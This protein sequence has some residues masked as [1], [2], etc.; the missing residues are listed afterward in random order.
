MTARCNLP[1][2]EVVRRYVGGES[3]LSLGR[4]Y[5]VCSTTI[6]NHLRRAGIKRR[7]CGA[8]PG[9]LNARKRG[10]PYSSQGQGYLCS[11]DRDSKLTLVHRACWEAYHGAIPKKH[12]VHHIT[13]DQL[14]NRIENLACMTQAVHMRLHAA[15]RRHHDPSRVPRSW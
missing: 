12:I 15:A 13:G 3:T 14:D 7:P 10:G 1:I 5:G 11:T 6:G 8:Q 9:C 4:L 2:K